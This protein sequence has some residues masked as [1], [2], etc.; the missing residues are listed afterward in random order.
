MDINWRPFDEKN[1]PAPAPEKERLFWVVDTRIGLTRAFVG[2]VADNGDVSLSGCPGRVIVTHWAELDAPGGALPIVGVII[3]GGV[4]QE[5]ISEIPVQIMVIDADIEGGD[6]DETSRLIGLRGEE[7]D[8]AASIW[9]SCVNPWWCSENAER[10]RRVKD[11]YCPECKQDVTGVENATSIADHGRC[12][13][14]Q[15]KWQNGELE[16]Q[17]R[18]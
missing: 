8:A 9:T 2:V 15:K 18:G 3:E 13:D 11:L 16:C 10:I 17:N 1:R 7:Y 5:A 6:P 12:F 4:L 14:C